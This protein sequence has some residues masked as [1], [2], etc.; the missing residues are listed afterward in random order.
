METGDLIWWEWKK[1]SS[2]MIRLNDASLVYDKKINK[3]KCNIFGTC[4]QLEKDALLKTGIYSYRIKRPGCYSFLFK[5][6]EKN[7]EVIT[8]IAAAAP[9]D[10]KLIITDVEGI[11]N[12]LNVHPEDRVWFMWDN[13][14]RPHNIR[15]VNHQN[16]IITDGFLSGSLM[17]SPATYVQAFD[18]LGIFY[19]RS[20]NA[21]GILG[22]IVCV[23][24][25][26][27]EIVSVNSTSIDPDPVIV[28]L[29]DVVVWE[30]ERRQIKDLALITSDEDLKNYS[31]T[32]Q[33]ILPTRFIS[34]AFNEPGVFHFMSPSFDKALKS[35]N[36]HDVKIMKF[37]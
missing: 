24:E 34:K 12:I 13:A 4:I 11:P 28:S 25:P 37:C 26:K 15:Q 18:E 17:E 35:E 8:I 31:K 2:A 16:Q 3:E 27:I 22:A 29:N 14:K 20:D 10:H 1:F 30:F 5:N 21:Q 7:A 6:D 36:T 32:A 9:K 33:D 19:Y 23:P